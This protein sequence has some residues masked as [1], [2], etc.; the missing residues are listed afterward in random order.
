VRDVRNQIFFLWN[1]FNRYDCIWGIHAILKKAENKKFRGKD[2][3][4]LAKPRD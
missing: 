1:G 2:G 3:G 4:E